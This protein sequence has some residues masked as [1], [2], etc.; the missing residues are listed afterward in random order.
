MRVQL[1]RGEV[2]FILALILHCFLGLRQV[3]GPRLAILLPDHGTRLAA[4]ALTGLLR[5]PVKP[6]N[7][8]DEDRGLLVHWYDG[9]GLRLVFS[10]LVRVHAR[11]FEG[12][13]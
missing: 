12:A 11:A 1:V 3:S 10:G 6:H 2:D 8:G 4:I 5:Q 7:A 9:D 13:L